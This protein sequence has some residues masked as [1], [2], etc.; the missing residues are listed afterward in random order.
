LLE[1]AARLTPDPARRADRELAAAWHK[2]GAGAID[3]A[4][5]LLA[6]SEAGPPDELRAAKVMH[7]RGQI[8]LYQRRAA[9]AV[10]LLVEAAQHLQTHDADL[11]RET[12][13]E[14]LGAAIFSST[15]DEAAITVAAAARTAM[16]VDDEST[17][18]DLILDGLATRLVDGHAAAVPSLTRALLKVRSIDH[19][20]DDEDRLLG[21]V[22]PFTGY[23]ATELWDFEAGRAVADLLVQRARA[24]GALIQLQ[25][26]ANELA[27]NDLLAGRLTDAAALVEEDRM[28]SD[29]TGNPPVGYAA[30]LLAAV[31]GTASAAAQITAAR[32]HTMALGEGRIVNFAGYALALLHN[33][34]RRH[35][36]ALEAARDV[37]HRDV[38]AGYQ[39][40][41]IS[42]L[43]EAASRTGD[44]DLVAAALERM[45]ARAQ[46]TPTDWALGIE[47]RLQALLGRE[48]ADASYRQSIEHL[49]RAGLRLEVARGHLLYGE[50]L[51]RTGQRSEARTQLHTAHEMLNAVGA[52]AF[53]DR[54]R[55][56]LLVLGVKAVRRSVESVEGLTAQEFHISTLARDGLSNAEIGTRLFLSPRTVE[57]HL[58]KVFTKLGFS[59]RR[60]LRNAILDFAPNDQLLGPTDQ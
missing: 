8:A 39:M 20:V 45:S 44:T 12:Y 10:R 53:A 51:R 24:T 21:A 26:T 42:E 56:E 47:A 58:G 9:D 31:R 34:L 1:R 32:D 16:P 52:A 49:D 27:V 37:F 19:R 22:G 3:D 55:R 30:I 2:R 14:A 35:D 57:W 6:S 59:S 50:W 38:L 40:M 48:D 54:A 11:A 17:I 60:Q 25:F 4:L 13:L 33:G 46:A 28:V 15:T 41:V 5:A 23:L 43:A 36:L 7:L 18:T 29:L